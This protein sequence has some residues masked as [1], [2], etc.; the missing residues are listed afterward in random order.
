[1][2]LA[3]RLAS[4]LSF[5]TLATSAAAQDNILL[6]IADDL[7]VDSLSAYNAGTAGASLP[8][9]PTLDGLAA[10]GLRFTQAYA[11]PVCS[12]TRAAILTGQHA[13]RT[14]V[15]TVVTPQSNNSLTAGAFTLPEAFAANPALG[16]QL[17][18]FGKWHLSIGPGTNM[19]R[20]TIGGWPSFAGFNGGQVADYQSWVRHV[21]DGTPAGTSSA[22][23]TN[24]AT[25]QTV[26]DALA[27][28]AA[29]EA[30]GAPWFA[31]V[32][33]GA[34]HAPFHL[35]P[36]ALCPDY[37][38]LPGGA[39]IALNPRPY[40]E[41][42]IQ[43]L[44][45]ELGRLLAGIDRAHTNILFVSDNGTP[46][47]VLQPPFPAGRG[48]GTLYEGG[49]RVPLIVQGP[50][51]VA[52]GRVADQ[53]LHVVDL[54]DTILELAGISR[55]SCAPANTDFD[56]RSLGRLVRDESQRRVRIYTEH[57][58]SF[59]PLLGGRVL[60]DE[61][62]KLIEF[63]NGTR[64]LYDLVNDPLEA[65]D[66]LASPLGSFE[67]LKLAE[68]TDALASHAS[69]AGAALCSGDEAALDHTTTCPCGNFGALGNGCAHSFD[70]R[71]AQLSASG[72]T[73]SD[74]VRLSASSL[75]GSSFTLFLQH[76]A[77]GDAVFHDG[78]L[79]AAGTL[80]R[81]RGRA[82][83]AGRAAFPDR[84]WDSTLTLSQRGGVVVGSGARRYYSAWYRNASSS[85]CPPATANV[86]NGWRL[87]W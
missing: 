32:A 72:S 69:G 5:L 16:Y 25:T 40:Y 61:R 75:P 41:A 78:V 77:A 17:A 56:T 18:T 49:I 52:P 82:A 2:S 19:A 4:A 74:D 36:A 35:P 73:A 6:V 42:A 51:V 57:F 55:P 22:P 30:L 68:L 13:W 39:D 7:G 8:A 28:I 80:L 38:T 65:V 63:Q 24:Y 20:C 86:S 43:A 11:N 76:D 10:S 71:G 83:V 1:M 29:Q 58:D 66:L 87:D 33:F 23:C 15:G 14:G 64:E 44:D 27:W 48:K 54:F 31:W 47:E 59:Q 46:N 9:T 85:F 12:P 81:L 62:Y 67:A 60:R 79:C 21:S 3:R 50:A 26:D 70:P 84:A 34:P 53:P 37:A 45:T